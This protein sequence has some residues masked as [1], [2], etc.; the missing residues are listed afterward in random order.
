MARET[1]AQAIARRQRERQVIEEQE[2][3]A[4]NRAPATAWGGGVGARPGGEVFT[5]ALRDAGSQAS[6]ALRGMQD[7]LTLGLGDRLHAGGGA[8]IHVRIGGTNA[9][10]TMYV[11]ITP[12]AAVMP[13]CRSMTVRE[14]SSAAKPT[15]VVS[16][17]R[18]HATAIVTT[19]LCPASSWLPER[20]SSSR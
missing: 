5:G 19:V 8:L 4:R 1:A 12:S 6:A 9:M 3:A 20:A 13:K 16:V 10:V 15:A 11:S 14:T 17:V 2:H 7:A 18:K